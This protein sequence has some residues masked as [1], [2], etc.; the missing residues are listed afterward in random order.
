[1]IDSRVNI[2]NKKILTGIIILGVALR[3]ISVFFYIG[4]DKLD[5]QEY[6]DIAENLVNGKGYSFY[7][8]QNGSLEH[9]YDKNSEAQ[10]SAYMPPLYTL[11]IAPL[12]ISDDLVVE[13][14]LLACLNLM[15]F[16]LTCILLLVIVKMLFGYRASIFAAL[17]YCII[18]EF[19]YATTSIGTTQLYHLLILVFIYALLTKKS[20][21]FISI[22]LGL[23]LLL[24]F[25]LILL[26]PILLYYLINKLGRRKTLLIISI[27]LM[28]LM[29]WIIRNFIVFNEFIPFSTSGGLNIYRGNN[30]Q[31]LG[32]WHN[33]KTLEF[34]NNSEGLELIEPRLSDKYKEEFY[35]FITVNPGKAII[36]FGKKIFYSITIYPIDKN[37]LSPLY[38]IPWFFLLITSIAGFR[39]DKSELLYY[40]I[41]FHLIIAV[42]FLPLP[43]Y[44]TMMKLF[45]IPYSANYLSTLFFRR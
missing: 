38:Y 21:P 35:E 2:K 11:I 28:F 41:G 45:L 10:P 6:G 17:I 19:V 4:L 43:R 5:Q 29:P 25:E 12:K 22:S 20:I 7:Y 39:K 26:V 24:R 3:I 40:F 9:D 18:P 8:Y 31:V 42:I 23:L 13:N 14:T 1:M 30:E 44:M 15:F 37:T 34:I 32:N 16:V 27:A 33:E 36:N